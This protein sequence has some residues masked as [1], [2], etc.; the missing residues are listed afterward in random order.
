MNENL[1]LQIGSKG[2]EV[3]K[4]QSYMGI[5]PDQSFGPITE[6]KLLKLKGVKRIS[7]KQYLNSPTINQLIIKSGSNVMA[8]SKTGTKI[9]DA[10]AKADTSYFSNHKVVKTIAYGQKVG[11]IRSA[12][13]AGNWYAIYYDDG[14]FGGTKVG[15]VLASE[16]EKY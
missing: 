16:I 10:E 7:L 2:L 8:K 14:F 13:P 12:N 6:A 11:T 1:V 4:L 3:G 15:F 9:Y 5:T